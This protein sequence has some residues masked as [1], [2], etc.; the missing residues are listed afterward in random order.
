M[1][2]RTDVVESD[3]LDVADFFCIF[4]SAKH[5]RKSNADTNFISYLLAFFY[6]FSVL[7][8]VYEW[9]KKTEKNI[10]KLLL[11]KWL[12]YEIKLN[13]RDIKSAGCI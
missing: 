6:I 13:Y 4:L 1:T 11:D 2:Y 5:T 7:K 9:N 8:S 12:I 10:D 3:A